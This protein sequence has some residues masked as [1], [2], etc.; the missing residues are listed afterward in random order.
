MKNVLIALLTL[1]LIALTV[2]HSMRTQELESD[3]YVEQQL[4]KA[5]EAQIMWVEMQLREGNL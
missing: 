3:L 4:N 2:Y 1:N 5:C